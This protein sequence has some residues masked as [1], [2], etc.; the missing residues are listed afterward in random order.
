M[1]MKKLLRTA[2]VAFAGSA[3]LAATAWGQI[4]VPNSFTAGEAAFA[5]DVNANF[6]A[7][8]DGVNANLDAIGTNLAA[9]QGNTDV[10]D[11]DLRPAVSGYGSVPP[12]AA[13]G[14]PENVNIR[15]QENGDGTFN[16]QVWTSFAAADGTNT[17]TFDSVN[18]DTDGTT[19]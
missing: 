14:E 19:V 2:F 18:T 8:V 9:I 5:A 13:A 4:S 6:E 12:L 10:L 7:V 15:R 17:W 3:L 16:Y 11:N 1:T